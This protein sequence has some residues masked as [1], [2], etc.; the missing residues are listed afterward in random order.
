MVHY[1]LLIVLCFL[2]LTRTQALDVSFI[3]NDENAPLPLSAK[4]RDSLRKLCVLMQAGDDKVPPEL[5]GKKAVLGK[6]CKK[7]ARDDANIGGSTFDLSSWDLSLKTI[8]ISLISVGGGYVAWNNRRFL[9]R[10]IRSFFKSKSEVPV[11]RVDRDGAGGINIVNGNIIHGDAAPILTDRE[12]DMAA[13]RL[14][15]ARE[16]RLRRFTE[17]NKAAG[18][19]PST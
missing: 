9:G 3:P 4:Y 8:V 2:L 18:D 10:K 1:V 5:K 12:A 15:E 19:S 14:I 7:L 11:Q 17:I 6:M 13:R 16:A